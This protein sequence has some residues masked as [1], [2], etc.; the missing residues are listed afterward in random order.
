MA[1]TK[2][3]RPA[4]QG[5]SPFN[6]RITNELKRRLAE[7][8]GRAHRSLTEEAEYRLARDF[9]EDVDEMRKEAAKW[10][11]A[12]RTQALHL[13]G[14]QLLHEVPGR[15]A[16]VIVDI[17]TLSATADGLERGLRSGFTDD[18]PRPL[19]TEDAA[20][21]EKEMAALR[22]RVEEALAPPKKPG[23]VA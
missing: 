4:K 23:K 12:A 22:R 15:P 8:A 5:R 13:A 7:S 2:R 6:S 14:Y 16:R 18:A 20:R 1:P 19:T 10:L 21:I 17:E 3:G 9:A 11:S